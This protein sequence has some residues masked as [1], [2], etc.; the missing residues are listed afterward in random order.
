MTRPEPCPE[1]RLRLHG[2][3]DGELD[4]AHAIEIERHLASCAGCAAE[5]RT[6]EALRRTLR[7][8]DVRWPVPEGLRERVIAIADGAAGATPRPVVRWGALQAAFDYLRAWSLVPSAAML[9]AA[10]FLVF[11]PGQDRSL[12]DELVA[13]HVRSLLAD[14]LTDVATSNRHTV[15]PWFAGR[16]DY[17]PPVVDLAAQGFPLVGGRVDYVGGRVVAVLVYRRDGHTINLF[18][19]PEM[20]P[21]NASLERE[22]YNLIEWSQAGLNFWAV[23]DLNPVELKEFLEDFAAAAPH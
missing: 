9:A 10:L 14:H 11:S 17:S 22:G 23:S 13:S 8:D 18:T 16:V 19:W 4:A 12:Q 5:L 21:A 15:K 3:V 20:R 1:W 7:R 2:L 6:L